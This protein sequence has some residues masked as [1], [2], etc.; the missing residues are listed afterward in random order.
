MASEDDNFIKRNGSKFMH[1]VNWQSFATYLLASILSFAAIG[2]VYVTTVDNRIEQNKAHV[3]RVD[4]KTGENSE[5]IA[6]LLAGQ[7]ASVTAVARLEERIAALVATQQAQ[8]ETLQR[9]E[10]LLQEMARDSYGPPRR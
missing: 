1:R 8:G 3:E 7:A 10:A 9:I 6:S 4:Q 5:K 2:G